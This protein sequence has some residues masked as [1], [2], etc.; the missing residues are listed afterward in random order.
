MIKLSGVD[1]Y[2]NKGRQ[3]EIHD[4]SERHRRS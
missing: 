4:A 3:N 2:F 1:K